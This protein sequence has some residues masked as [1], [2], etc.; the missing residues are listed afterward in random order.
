ML[1][2][3]YNEFEIK[4]RQYDDSYFLVYKDGRPF[5]ALGFST[6]EVAKKVL[7]RAYPENRNSM[8]VPI[9][10]E[11]EVMEDEA[12]LRTCKCGCKKTFLKAGTRA[13]YFISG[14]N[15]TAYYRKKKKLWN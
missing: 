9:L 11:R 6:V 5:S 1:R 13:K 7:D 14:H 10:Q 15:N 4:K 2:F 8:L 12:V 3:R